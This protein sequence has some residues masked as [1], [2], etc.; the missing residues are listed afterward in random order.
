VLELLLN[1]EQGKL[2]V[3]L[4]ARNG[5]SSSSINNDTLASAPDINS[6]WF[7]LRNRNKN[8]TALTCGMLTATVNS[9]TLGAGK[10][11]APTVIPVIYGNSTSGMLHSTHCDHACCSVANLSCCST[12]CYTPAVHS[13]AALHKG[14]CCVSTRTVAS[15]LRSY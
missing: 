10:C 7:N 4:A 8:Q 15:R 11:T 14:S 3:L 12:C 13:T 2:T 1:S 5:N 9:V 6:F